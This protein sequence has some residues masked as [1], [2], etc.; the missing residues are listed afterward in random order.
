MKLHGGLTCREIYKEIGE[1]QFRALE[2]KALATLEGVEGS[3]IALGG[4]AILDPRYQLKGTH[5]YLDVEKE[6]LQ[7][8]FSAGPL[9]PFEELY[10]QRLPLYEKIPGIRIVLKGKSEEQIINE[11]VKYGQ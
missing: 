10:H 3:V 2:Q 6:V 8:R 5:L 4:G 7:E 11:M 1:K 9:P